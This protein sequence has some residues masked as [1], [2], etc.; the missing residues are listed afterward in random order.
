MKSL[1]SVSWHGYTHREDVPRLRNDFT[2]DSILHFERR[3]YLPYHIGPTVFFQ[4]ATMS[5]SDVDATRDIVE[6]S[7]NQYFEVYKEQISATATFADKAVRTFDTDSSV[8]VTRAQ[9]A[10]AGA[11][12]AA[13][14]FTILASISA[15][16]SA[17]DRPSSRRISMLFWPVT[18]A[19][20]KFHELA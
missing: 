14:A 19:G 1:G 11:C 17:S 2:Q 15:L 4:E 5:L 3:D 20:C 10:S 16:I 7:D 6:N 12:G 9:A 18:G 13:P 8:G